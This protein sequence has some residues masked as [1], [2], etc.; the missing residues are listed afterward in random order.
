MHDFN[1]RKPFV[2]S[3]IFPIRDFKVGGSYKFIISSVDTNLIKHFSSGLRSEK[4]I[5]LNGICFAI[6]DIKPINIKLKRNDV[7]ETGT[8]I[9]IKHNNTYFGYGNKLNA[10]EF[11]KHLSNS[12]RKK[13]NIFNNKQIET[14]NLINCFSN[15]EFKRIT[16]VTLNIKNNKTTIIGS[17]WSFQI[18][19]DISEKDLEIL[20]FNF[21]AGFGQKTSMGF[22]LVNKIKGE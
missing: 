1:F 13:Y 22:G 3:N 4:L 20:Q 21:D 15:T 10:D 7:I 6:T 12:L 19:P 14:F 17:K 9:V 5:D 16:A 11:F 18:T 2:Y 8:P